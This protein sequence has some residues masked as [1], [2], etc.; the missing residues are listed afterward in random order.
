LLRHGRHWL[1]VRFLTQIAAVPVS[2]PHSVQP[3]T[4]IELP[5]NNWIDDRINTT[6]A[7][8][9]LMPSPESD[10][11]TFLRRVTLDLTGRL[12]TTDLVRTFLNDQS[13]QKRPTL[14][15][16]LL[17]SEEYIDYWTYQLGQ[18]LRFRV[19]G[20]DVIAAERFYAWLRAQVAADRGWDQIARDLMLATGDS[21]KNPP[22]TF[23]RLVA[24]GRMQ[25]EYFSEVMLGVRLRCANCHNHPLD[26]W[27]QD[28]YHGLAQI[29]APLLRGQIVERDPDALLIHPRTGEPALPRIP[30]LAPM[31]VPVRGLE[32]LTDWL[33]SPD[34]P[35]FAR[36]VVGRVWRSLMGQGLIHPVDD[37]RATNPASD[38]QLLDALANDF[39]AHRLSLRHTIR[40][41]CNS[42]AY[43]RSGVPAGST[44][45]S[46]AELYNACAR[47]RPLS[48]EVLADAIADVTGVFEDTADRV[49][50][51]NRIVPGAAE[52]TLRILGRCDF[53]AGCVP[54]SS[55]PAMD[56]ATRLHLINGS[57]LN[58][59]L[60]DSQG[61][62]S[63]LIEAG[64]SDA[65][66]ID[67]L[68][69]LALGRPPS[70]D[71]Q[72]H[73]Y[74]EFSRSV[75]SHD[76]R[77]RIED[78]VWSLLNCQDFATNH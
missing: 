61:N 27:T 13:P 52:Q 59:R 53:T 21:Q 8:L 1:F 12:P 28:D 16:R 9:R 62:V 72:R 11:A 76:R 40:E 74:E 19:P 7:E 58:S 56:I 4:H 57:I 48:A 50:S 34:N 66:I 22:A 23:H 44:H 69:L 24:D 33:T 43:Q 68:Y 77:Q 31:S 75:D 60:T 37:T 39:R 45:R 2:A 41:I 26:R 17:D 64:H 30:G 55:Q 36:A 73:W 47:R 46:T 10:D 38:P 3:T 49:R 70:S 78:F 15:D 6:L 18:W 65:E 5:R 14:I 20:D 54:E 32:E 25:A 51:I 35:Y 67:T 71:E 63:K 29:F 42:A